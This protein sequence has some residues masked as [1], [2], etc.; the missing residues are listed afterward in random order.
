VAGGAANFRRIDEGTAV[1]RDLDEGAEESASKLDDQALA[2]EEVVSVIVALLAEGTWLIGLGISHGLVRE[3]N[4]LTPSRCSQG[5][6]GHVE[7]V[8]ADLE[9]KFLRQDCIVGVN[10]VDAEGVRGEA[11]ASKGLGGVGVLDA[12]VCHSGQA[13]GERS[14]GPGGGAL[15]EVLGGE[16]PGLSGGIAAEVMPGDEVD[17]G[18]L[19][20]D[21]H[22]QAMAGFFKLE[23]LGASFQRGRIRLGGQGGDASDPPVPD[24]RGRA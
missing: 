22:I 12:K 19:D 21:V 5:I 9:G 8:L 18:G 1:E 14:T 20:M 11:A 17:Q 16:G 10:T 6:E 24:R 2:A 15:E 3:E 13:V 4:G 23:G 7:L